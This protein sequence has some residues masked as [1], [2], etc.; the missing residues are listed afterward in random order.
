MGDT[1]PAWLHPPFLQA[2]EEITDRNLD[3]IGNSNQRLNGNDLLPAF[4]LA[5][6]FGVEMDFFRQCFLGETGFFT[7]AADGIADNLTMR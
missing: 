2:K 1:F 6:I 7:I 4:D 5:N 3:R